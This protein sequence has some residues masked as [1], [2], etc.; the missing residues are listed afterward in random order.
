MF[1][2]MD[3]S[4]KLYH[5]RDKFTAAAVDLVVCSDSFWA[6][7]SRPMNS[8]NKINIQICRFLKTKNFFTNIV[9]CRALMNELIYGVALWC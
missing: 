1:S 4:L 9:G 8:F 6:R 7:A 5:S 3:Q 2:E